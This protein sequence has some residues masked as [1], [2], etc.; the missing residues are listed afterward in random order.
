VALRAPGTPLDGWV[1][2]QLRKRFTLLQLETYFR[3]DQK[4]RAALRELRE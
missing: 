1:R 2:E 3:D 4:L